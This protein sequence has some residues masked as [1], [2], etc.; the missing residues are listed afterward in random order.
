M[1]SFLM[2]ER[3]AASSLWRTINHKLFKNSVFCL[4]TEVSGPMTKEIMP[5]DCPLGSRFAF[6]LG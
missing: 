1:N 5:W 2:S 3:S 4:D 6:C